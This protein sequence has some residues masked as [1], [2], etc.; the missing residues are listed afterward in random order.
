M[1][2]ALLF[3]LLLLIGFTSCKKD[4]DDGGGTTAQVI[5]PGVGITGLNLGDKAKVAID[6]YGSVSPSYGA[7]GGVYNHFLTYFSKGVIVYCEP[8]TDDTFNDQMLIGKITL[9]APYDG[10]TDKGIGIGSTKAE[11]KTAY[12]DPVSS[13]SFFG[14]EYAIGIT[15]VY[16]DGTEKVESI[17]I[18]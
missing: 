17:E 3:G 5:T 8:T 18:E 7:S 1:K 12:G 15:F 11:V 10:K 13:S 16:E 14:D 9:T 4:N 2:N 6:L